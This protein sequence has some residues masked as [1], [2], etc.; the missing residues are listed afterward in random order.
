MQSGF[1]FSLGCNVVKCDV[2][3]RYGNTLFTW[4]LV[5]HGFPLGTNNISQT[6]R[7]MDCV[8]HTQRRQFSSNTPEWMVC[9]LWQQQEKS[10]QNQSSLITFYLPLF[11]PPKSTFLLFNKIWCFLLFKLP[12]V[13]S[14]HRWMWRRFNT[15]SL[16]FSSILYLFACISSLWLLYFCLNSSH[17]WHRW[18]Q[19]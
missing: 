14:I 4:N 3:G 12:Y 2:F 15:L 5:E 9:M 16:F 7:E 17:L 13:Y 11:P 18:T 10:T 19:Q 8:C 1:Q 6:K